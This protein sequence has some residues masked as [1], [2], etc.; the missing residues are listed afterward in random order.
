MSLLTIFTAPKPFTNPHIATIQ[1]NALKSWAALGNDVDVVMIGN[2]VGMPE[3]ARELKIPHLAQVKCNS[4][5]TPLISSIFELGRQ[6]N[7]N[8]FLAYV[9]ADIILLPDMLDAV[10]CV[11]NTLPRFLIIGQRYDLQVEQELN[12]NANYPA[13]LRAWVKRDGQLHTRTGSDYFIF[14]RST[15]GDVPEFAVGRA[16]WDNWMIFHARVQKMPVIDATPSVMVIHQN[17]DYSH[18]PGG[19]THYKLPESNENLKLAGGRRNVFQLDDASHVLANGQLK[20]MKLTWRRFWRE[21]EIWPLIHLR[22]S[23]LG[24]ITFAIT[25]PGKAFQDLR[26]RLNLLIKNR[27]GK[28]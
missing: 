24:W 9:N 7:D 3:V 2:E 13:E 19:Q 14:P 1:R 12:F 27:K 15:F 28:A 20:K 16:R 5:G 22:S 11:M 6:F 10:R 21:F 4:Q 17:H 18:L 25:H 23:R 8:P 26:G